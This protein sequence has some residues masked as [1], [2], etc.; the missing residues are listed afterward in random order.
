MKLVYGQNRRQKPIELI[1]PGGRIVIARAF[2]GTIIVRLFAD[3]GTVEVE[4]SLD[5]GSGYKGGMRLVHEAGES[6]E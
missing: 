1:C 6:H 4:D 5:P 3:N 2:G